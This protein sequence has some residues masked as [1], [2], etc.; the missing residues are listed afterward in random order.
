MLADTVQ[1]DYDET[2]IDVVEAINFGKSEKKLTLL[3]LN[4]FNFSHCGLRKRCFWFKGV[5]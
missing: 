2:G 1:S 4:Q 5:Q 3:I